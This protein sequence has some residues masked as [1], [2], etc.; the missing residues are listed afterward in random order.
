MLKRVFIFLVFVNIVLFGANQKE[1]SLTTIDNKKIHIEVNNNGI[2]VKEFPNKIVILDFF[3]KNCPPCKAQ[4]PTL[5]KIQ[6]KY[7]DSLQIIGIHVQEPLDFADM[8]MIQKRGVN[9]LVVDYLR[10]NQDFVEYISNLTG[11]R[12]QIPYMLFFDI[13][14]TYK[15]YHLGMMQED[16]LEKFIEQ[17]GKK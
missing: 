1:F 17:N 14:G 8:S 11:W 15:G 4:M 16:L 2:K 6:K 7:K 5:G 10:G 3:G 12:G 13:N 9:F